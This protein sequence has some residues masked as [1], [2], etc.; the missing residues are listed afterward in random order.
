MQNNKIVVVEDEIII[1]LDIKKILNKLGFEAVINI[2]SVTAAINAIEMYNPI[3]VL[4]DINLDKSGDGTLIGDYLLNKKIIPYIYVTSYSDSL[5][6]E[7]VNKTRPHGYIVKPFKSV[8]ISSTISIV[9]NSFYYQ[10]NQETA[11]L[12]LIPYRIKEVLNYIDTHVYERIDILNLVQMTKWKK[13][14]FIR[15]FRRTIGITPYQY[16]L[17]KKIEESK[18]MIKEI[19]KPLNE[20]SF[21]LGFESYANFCNAFK[22]ITETTPEKFRKENQ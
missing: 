8:D 16:I 15:E 22:K 14:H 20:I 4:I 7:K 13:D 11:A 1:A 9:L 3:L 18:T 10:K 12:A 17:K 6:L 5:T 21:E 19:D 2:T